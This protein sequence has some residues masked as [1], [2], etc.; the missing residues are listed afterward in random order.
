MRLLIFDYDGVIADTFADMLK[1]AQE[2]CDEL[3]V[4]HTVLPSDLR[5]LEVMSFTTFGRACEVRDE[6]TSEFVRR[7]TQKFAEKVTPPAIFDGLAEVIQRLAE[8]NILLIVSGNTTENVNAFLF[9]HGLLDCFRMV[10][11]VDIP[12]SKRCKIQMAQKRFGIGREAV[13]FVGD[14]L[15]DLRAAREA[16]V[17]SIAV[18]WGHQSL[19]ML[20]GGR[21]DAIVHSPAE[22]YAVLG[23]DG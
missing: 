14:S 17:K 11:G 20:I 19:D 3:G 15:S 2:T 10:Y 13:N 6:L 12:G 5:D 9:H 21:P 4:T 18:S 22:L 8:R 7:C 23:S 1:F 16:G